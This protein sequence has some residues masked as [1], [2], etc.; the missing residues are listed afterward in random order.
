M[1]KA[2]QR[3]SEE[4]DRVAHYLDPAT[5]LKIREVAERELIA[6]HMRS[7]AEME[8]S[9][10]I[11]MIEDNKIEDLR[12]CYELYK[13]VTQ[14]TPGLQVRQEP[15]LRRISLSLS[16]SLSHTHTHTHTSLSQ[17]SPLSL[18][19]SLTR[20]PAGHSRDYGSARQVARHAAGPGR[21]E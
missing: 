6:R 21:A 10:I 12:R 4:V 8:H 17:L 14:P 20:P 2:E 5:E 16:L 1:K 13:R 15:T 7:L 19:I 3:L 11:A 9:G 18:T